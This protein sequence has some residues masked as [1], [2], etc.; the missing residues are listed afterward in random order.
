MKEEVLERA[1]GVIASA[2][3]KRRGSVPLD[4]YEVRP[5]VGGDGDEFLWITVVYDGAPRILG[6]RTTGTVRR[7]LRLKLQ[8]ADV[9]AF[10]VIAFT[11]RSDLE[12]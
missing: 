6:G 10:P 12:E 4:L 7:R 11:A 9:E 5:E 3:Q 8:E 2:L 1:K